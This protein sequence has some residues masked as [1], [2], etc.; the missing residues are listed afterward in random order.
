MFLHQVF[1]L[2]RIPRQLSAREPNFQQNISYFNY[3]NNKIYLFEMNRELK[4]E[5]FNYFKSVIMI[6]L[7]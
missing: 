1:H 3:Y 7:N 6:Y 5:I 2:K 4:Y